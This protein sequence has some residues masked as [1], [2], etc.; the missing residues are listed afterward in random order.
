MPFTKRTEFKDKL[1]EQIYIFHMMLVCAERLS[2]VGVLQDFD[3]KDGRVVFDSISNGKYT[4]IEVSFR[5]HDKRNGIFGKN[6]IEFG[7]MTDIYN[8]FFEDT[9]GINRDISS[10]CRN[11]YTIYRSFDSLYNIDEMD[12]FIE[13][14]INKIPEEWYFQESLIR[15]DYM[16]KYED[17]DRILEALQIE[18]TLKTCFYHELIPGWVLQDYEYVYDYIMGE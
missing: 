2:K 17:I 18:S 14:G 11:D 4:N 7:S 6:I 8:L 9:I 3:Y 15:P 13:G 16:H 1:D 10:E 12:S 5:H